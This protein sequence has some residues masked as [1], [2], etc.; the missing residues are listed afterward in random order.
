MIARL[1]A[2]LIVALYA[3]LG[4][5]VLKPEAVYSGD[6]G[7]KYVQAQA[8]VGHRFASLDIPYPGQ[9]IDP[10]RQFFPLRPPFVMT[11]GGETQAIFPPASSVLQ[12]AAVAAGGFRGMIALSVLAAAVILFSAYALAP[13]AYRLAVV[14]A[15]GLGGP[16]WFYAVSG[17][18]HAPAVAF[19]TAA[20]ACALRAPGSWRWAPF[21]AGALVGAGATL[22]DEVMLL[23]PG[24]LLAIGLRRRAWRP[25]AAA[26][27][28][29]LVPLALAAAVEVW[30]FNRP[31]AAHLR[32]AV[33]LLQTAFHVTDQPNP[34]LP[35][36]RP[37]STRERYDTVVTYW[38]FGRGTDRQVAAF[39]TALLVA[40]VVRWRWR[41]SLG[42]LLWVLAFGATAVTDLW[43]V[44]TAPKWLAGLVR[45]SPF[46]VFAILPYAASARAPA[47]RT[48][49][50]ADGERWL[51]AAI[52][53]TTVCYLLIAFAGVDTS[54]GKSL[55]PRL[56]LPLLPLLAVSSMMIIASYL[57][58]ASTIERAVGWAGGLLVAVAVVIH[59]AGTVPAYR[60]RNADEAAAVLAAAASPE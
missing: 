59:A 38:L 18:E 42:I 34:E 20:F 26:I 44:V 47:A 32:H 10:E 48:A 58:S 12:A 2:A 29:I 21:A 6:I 50:D 49:V 7:V 8:L 39:V 52:V 35:V 23:L 5:G 46:V 14:I 17:W 9:I 54:G 53:L 30:W 3:V 28:G 1:T 22:R 33:H 60:Q 37:M 4:L 45:V 16:L 55:G 25:L 24:L 43:E 19:G 40:L 36:L 41:S 27:A 31:P 11:V 57:R 56:L 51:P 13:S 15:V